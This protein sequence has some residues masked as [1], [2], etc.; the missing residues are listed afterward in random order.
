MRVMQKV[1]LP[2]DAAAF[3][4]GRRSTV[5]T[6]Y[7]ARSCWKRSYSVVLPWLW[8]QIGRLSWYIVEE[9]GRDRHQKASPRLFSASP[10]RARAVAEI[11]DLLL[12]ENEAGA[13]AH[14]IAA[15]VEHASVP[16]DQHIR[17]C[18]AEAEHRPGQVL[19]QLNHRVPQP[20]VI[21]QICVHLRRQADPLRSLEGHARGRSKSA[22]FFEHR[23]GI[24]RRD[25]AD[26]RGKPRATRPPALR[27]SGGSAYSI[28]GRSSGP[29]SRRCRA[30]NPH[31]FPQPIG[32]VRGMCSL[33][34]VAQLFH[35]TK[36]ISR[37][38]PDPSK[39]KLWLRKFF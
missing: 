4:G 37:T 28:V 25:K 34:A 30:G 8:A 2:S 33:L 36:A 16:A 39:V 22:S 32:E 19:V 6:R 15:E 29:N 5:L 1:A 24:V 10:M 21:P 20:K 9:L 35:A 13:L 17:P 27:R 3:S 18:A 23:Y 7:A 12:S 31:Q 38:R 26:E 11:G 14:R